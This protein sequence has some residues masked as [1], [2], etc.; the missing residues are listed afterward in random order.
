VGSVT[1]HAGNRDRDDLIEGAGQEERDASDSFHEGSYQWPPCRGTAG[2][3]DK[4]VGGDEFSFLADCRTPV[5]LREQQA[6]GQVWGQLVEPQDVYLLVG[7]DKLLATTDSSCRE[8]TAEEVKQYVSSTDAADG[9]R[10]DICLSYPCGC[11]NVGNMYVFLG[12]IEGRLT[13]Q[14]KTPT[15]LAAAAAC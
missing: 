9:D 7:H 11:G 12:P 6:Q 2:W 8:A 14:L 10:F 4:R 13:G 15:S 1:G 5:E 3:G